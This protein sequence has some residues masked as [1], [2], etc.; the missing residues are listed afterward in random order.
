LTRFWSLRI[1]WAMKPR[2]GIGVVLAVVST[3]AA[4]VAQSRHPVIFDTDFVMPPADDGMALIL[5]LSSPELD[6]L[7]VTT[8]AGNESMEKATVDALRLLE[9]AGHPEIPVYKGANMPLL[10]EKSDYATRVHGRWWSDEP[11]SPPPG[12]FARKKAEAESAVSFIVRTV[13]AR[14]GEVSILAIGPL[15][16]IAM[17]IRQEPGLAERVKE[18]VIMGGAV[19]SLP[20]GAGNVTPNAEFNFW[21]D[22]EAAKAVLRS[23]IPR[24]GLSPLNVSRKTAL[25]RDWYEKMVAVDT[26]IASLLK[27]TVGPRFVQEPS[28][29]MLMYDQVAVASLVDPTLVKT[30]DL[31]V[32]VDVNQG[33]DYGVSVGG[34]ELWPGADGARRMAV[35]Y[36]LD[37]PRFIELFVQRV[38]KVSP[39]GR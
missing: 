38:R 12:G 11:P 30:A 21:V 23:S 17:A 35:Q 8:V 26:P 5:A 15:T 1:V 32:D 16:N 34:T 36:D 22:P 25:T 9:I 10:H 24:I 31:Y 33:I 3:A 39:P 6:V 37:W 29:R 27:E 14:P 19:A 4:A 20:E 28:R 2:F 18:I 7:G 13:M